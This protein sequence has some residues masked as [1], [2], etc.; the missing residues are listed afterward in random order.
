[1]ILLSAMQDSEDLFNNLISIQPSTGGGAA[2][3]SREEIIQ[4]QVFIFF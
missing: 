1:M 2:G 4:D 3:K